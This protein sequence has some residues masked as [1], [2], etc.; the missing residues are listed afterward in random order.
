MSLRTHV[1][2]ALNVPSWEF[3]RANVEEPSVQSRVK[4][5]LRR[6]A[7]TL[8]LASAGATTLGS[9]NGCSNQ[10]EGERCTLFSMSDDAGANGTSECQSG[11]VCQGAP[12]AFTAT[13]GTLPGPGT[14]GVC[15]PP[16]G[17]TSTVAA[18]QPAMGGSTN[19]G[20][21]SGDGSFDGGPD[22]TTGDATTDAPVSKDA[23]K[24]ALKDAAK[25]STADS[26]VDAP[27]DV[28]TDAPVEAA[29]DAAA[30]T[31]DA[32]KDATSGG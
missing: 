28:A 2:L 32:A 20:Q 10:G 6:L 14:L 11:L 4:T 30:D 5:T 29:H 9:M 7:V 8:A 22:A 1:T 16:L 23:A 3:A 12:Q 19:G 17:T 25:D 26:T 24:D 18:C 27:K 31:S 15:C 21:P 13:T